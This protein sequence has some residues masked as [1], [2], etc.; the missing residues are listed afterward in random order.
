MKKKGREQRLAAE[1]DC[2]QNR[3]QELGWGE[4]EGNKQGGGG[5]RGHSWKEH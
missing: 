2:G 1:W 4:T 3:Q 5:G